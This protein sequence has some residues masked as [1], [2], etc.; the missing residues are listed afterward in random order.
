MCHAKRGCRNL[1]HAIVQ[2][3]SLFFYSRVH[4][5]ARRRMKDWKRQV[6][7]GKLEGFVI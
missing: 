5:Q 1:F 3:L 6:Y 4:V 2:H 7:M